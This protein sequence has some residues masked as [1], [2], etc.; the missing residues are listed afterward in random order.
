MGIYICMAVSKA[1][2]QAEWEKAYRETVTLVEKLP[3][4]DLQRVEIHGNDI[5]C[6][7]PAKEQELAVGGKKTKGWMVSGDLDSLGIAETYTLYENFGIDSANPE[8]GDA[9]LG[10]IPYHI[11]EDTNDSKFHQAYHLWGRKTQGEDYHIYLLAIAALLET[12]LKEKVFVYGDITKGQYKAAVEIAN[13]Y[14]KEPI[15]LPDSCDIERFCER[16]CKLPLSGAEKI[17]VIEEFYLGSKNNDYGECLRKH[18]KKELQNYW[19]G[20]FAQCE[21]GTSRFHR[22]FQKYINWGF[23]LEELFHL[24]PVQNG[25][26]EDACKKLI[27]TIQDSGLCTQEKDLRDPLTI[28]AE[29]EQLYGVATLFM[30][31]IFGAARNKKVAKYMPPEEVQAI[32]ERN[33]GKEMDIAAYM[34]EHLKKE[35]PSDISEEFSDF[36]HQEKEKLEKDHEEYDIADSEDLLYYQKGNSILPSLQKSL[37]KSM[38]FLESILKEERYQDLLQKDADTQFHWLVMQKRHYC[39]QKED[40]ERIYERLATSKGLARYY[41]L[42]RIQLGQESIRNMATALLVNDELWDF[43]KNYQEKHSNDEE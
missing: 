30:Q 23:E 9:I 11:K 25:G 2:T 32:L 18:F 21:L 14:L 10:I 29:S 24:I 1:V 5:P 31:G 3:L 42:F 28:N 41:A 34:E 20:I 12:R 26:K 19:T 15:D 22:E 38:T 17:G 36:F 39:I 33:F 6:V 27:E 4:A 40:W 43:C 8:A 7:V 35:K 16:V 13:Q 37:G